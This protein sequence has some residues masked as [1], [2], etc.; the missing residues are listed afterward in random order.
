MHVCMTPDT[1]LLEKICGAL[2]LTLTTLARPLLRPCLPLPT[3]LRTSPSPHAN[4]QMFD[5]GAGESAS[6]TAIMAQVL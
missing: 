6:M 5:V 2:E 1:I 3:N 4:E